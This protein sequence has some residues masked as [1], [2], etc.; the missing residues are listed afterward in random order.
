M[1]LL[2][3]EAS[4]TEELFSKLASLLLTKWLVDNVW[5]SLADGFT[6]CLPLPLEFNWEFSSVA[7]Q[8]LNQ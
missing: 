2:I 5:I 1:D 7:A 8:N 4:D 6:R 3:T